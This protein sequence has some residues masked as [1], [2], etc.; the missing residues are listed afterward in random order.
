MQ[1]A[2]G[3]SDRV[4]EEVERYSDVEV[5]HD[6]PPIYNYWS[7]RYCLPLFQEL[8]YDG[9][10]EFWDAHVTEVCRTRAPEVA[11]VVSLGAGNGDIEIGIAHRLAETGIHNLEL[12]LL[13]LNPRMLERAHAE[14]DAL[15]IGDRLTTVEADL[16][17]W[18]A[19]GEADVYFAS[20]SLHHVVELEHLFDEVKRTL[21][22]DGAFLIND[23]IGRNGHE[24]WP[25]AAAF[26]HSIWSKMPERY[27]YNPLH[28]RVDEVYPDVDYSTEGFEGIRAEDILPLLLERF[29]PD[30]FITFMNVIDPFVDRIYGRNFDPERAE[31]QR[32]INLVGQLDDAT[33][34]LRL[35]TPTHLVGSFRT[36]PCTARFPRSRS[37]DA[38]LRRE[39][40]AAPDPQRGQELEL[41]LAEKDRELELALGNYNSLR[42]RKAVRAGLRIADFLRHPLRGRGS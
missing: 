24:R 15:G 4:A 12:V 21:R 7:L 31:D 39:E 17:S 18:R 33:L 25:E 22:P 1:G 38:V 36:R 9:L 5:I 32:F 14:A 10:N 34:D 29:H 28:Q 6:L 11:R 37:P 13:E 30:A 26:V 23:M 41:M 35:V 20:H 19:D 16:N 40:P 27:R 42:R 8:G 3:Y 2:E